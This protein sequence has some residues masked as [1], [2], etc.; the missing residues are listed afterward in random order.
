MY[1]KLKDKLSPVA[2]TRWGWAGCCA[3]IVLAIVAF[4]LK[5][6]G[7]YILGAVLILFAIFSLSIWAVVGKCPKCGTPVL[8][9]DMYCP[10][11]RTLLFVKP[12]DLEEFEKEVAKEAAEVK[13]HMA[14]EAHKDTVDKT[15]IRKDDPEKVE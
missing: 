13:A 5:T 14:E 11:C 7:G 4:N 1:E 12:K 3:G 8:T 15:E 10:K 6:T 9:R 2:A